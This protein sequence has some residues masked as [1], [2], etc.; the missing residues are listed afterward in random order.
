MQLKTIDTHAVIENKLVFKDAQQGAHQFQRTQ[1]MLVG[2]EP[3]KAALNV[4]H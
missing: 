2:R 4:Q 3:G 1:H